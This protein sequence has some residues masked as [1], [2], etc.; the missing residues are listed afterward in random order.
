MTTRISD[1][2]PQNKNNYFRI[3]ER[4][5]TLAHFSAYFR[6]VDSSLYSCTLEASADVPR[7]MV[8]WPAGWATFAKGKP[9]GLVSLVPSTDYLAV[10]SG[11]S[12]SR[13]CFLYYVFCPTSIVLLT[14][15]SRGIIWLQSVSAMFPAL[16][17]LSHDHCSA[18]RRYH[19][20]PVSLGDAS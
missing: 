6:T 10:S 18:D 8:T 13:R 19:L 9:S 15:R 16:C 7:H 11:S 17:P 12:Q 2:I 3:Y 4:I 14:D 1:K 20:A 5:N